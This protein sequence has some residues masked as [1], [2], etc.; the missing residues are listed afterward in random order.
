MKSGRNI[1]HIEDNPRDVKLV[2]RVL[3]KCKG[4]NDEKGS[5]AQKLAA[6]RAD[7][8]SSGEVSVPVIQRPHNNSFPF[9]KLSPWQITEG[10][11]P[12]PF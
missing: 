3:R 5:Q 7:V 4:P 2:R 9:G 6:H 12:W 1:L 11:P 10:S 8:D